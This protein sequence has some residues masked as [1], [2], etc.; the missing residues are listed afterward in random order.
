MKKLLFIFFF[1]Q[2][3]GIMQAQNSSDTTKKQQAHA[4][5]DDP[6][7]FFTRIEFFNELQ[8]YDK[9]DIFLNQTVLRTVV[10]IGNKFT[11]RID[12]PY[13]YNSFQSPAK[14]RQS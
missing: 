12:L 8:R 11:T 9:K 1:L 4:N 7:Q 2:Q 10:K 13:V 5:A 6:S 14:L 3:T